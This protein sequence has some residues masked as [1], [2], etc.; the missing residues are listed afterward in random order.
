MPS[1]LA[2]S[3]LTVC[4]VWLDAAVIQA[5]VL[6]RQYCQYSGWSEV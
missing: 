6:I 4:H 1:I 3:V 5:H 2:A